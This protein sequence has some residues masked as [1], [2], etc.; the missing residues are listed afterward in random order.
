[1]LFSLLV[2]AATAQVSVVTEGSST[3]NCLSTSL[4]FDQLR[5]LSTTSSSVDVSKYDFTIDYGND[6]VKAIPGGGVELLVSKDPGTGKG[7][8]ARLSTTRYHLY[9]KFSITMKSAPIAGIVTTFITMSGRKDEID[10]EF[11]G[12]DVANAQTNVFY[13][14]ITEFAVHGKTH[15]L[16]SGAI[17]GAHTYTIDWKSTGITWSIDGK[18]VRTYNNDNNAVSAMTPAGEHWF[19]STPSQLQIAVWDGCAEDQSG[20][21]N[22]SKGPINWGSQTSF[23]STFLSLDIQCYDD[24]NQPVKKWPMAPGNPDAG[25][26]NP[27]QQPTSTISNGTSGLPEGNLFG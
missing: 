21:C 20:T 6:N 7:T 19:P 1:M 23:K 13:K 3:G 22:W 17:D 9:G 10:W 11:V 14:G 5:T 4:K 25:P 2:T 27:S 26:S 15:P 16:P 12:G 24:K 18:V 8:G